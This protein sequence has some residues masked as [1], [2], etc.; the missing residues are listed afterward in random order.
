MKDDHLYQRIAEIFRQEILTGAL[1]PG[2]RL[3]SVR[4]MAER[5]SCTIGTIQRAYQELVRQGL[6]SSRAG[7]GTHVIQQSSSNLSSLTTLRR[8]TLIH[9]AEAYLLEV[10]TSGYSLEEAEGALRQA[11]DR[12]RTVERE[13]AQVDEQTLRFVG[14]HDL[15]ISWLASHFPEIA[16]GYSLELRLTG[17]LGGLISLAD[18]RADIAGSHLWDEESG[19]FNVPFVRRFFPGQKMG[20][21]NLAHRRMGLILPA[22]NPLGLQ[23]LADLARPGLRFANRQAGSG[24]RVWLDIALRNA[25]I[26]PESIRG[27]SDEKMTHLAVARSVAE[28]EADAGFGLEAAA[29]NYGLDFLLLTHDCYDLVI[30]AARIETPPV[31]NLVEW[32]QSKTTPEVIAGLGGYETQETGKVSWV[33]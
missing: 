29:R 20:L 30:H 18:G 19:E 17:S 24:T 26:Q 16:P 10:M 27:H 31:K 2:D 28:G 8:A 33:V 32:L 4:A 5:W 11:L 7:Q 1:K 22:G 23:G 25:G 15:A 6:V 21:V 13:P 9:R 3:P 12:W 14:S